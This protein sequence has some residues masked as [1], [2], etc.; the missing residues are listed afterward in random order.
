MFV[1]E[2]SAEHAAIHP[3]APPDRIFTGHP[4]K[5]TVFQGP[6]DL[7]LYLIERDEIDIFDIPIEPITNEYLHYL[8]RLESLNI[9]VCG[10]FL[11]MAAHLLEIK[12]RMLLPQQ[13]RPP[14]EEEEA[15]DPRAEL[16]ARLLEY[17]RYKRVAE[18]LRARA[19]IQ[20]FVFSRRD[21]VNGNGAETQPVLQLNEVSAFDLWAAFQNVL[22]RVKEP[23][24]GEV[25]RARFSVAQ[26]MAAVASRLK[27]S[28]ED[29][30]KF[31][32]LF[33]EAV[34]RIELVVTF[35][36]L[37]EL[38]RLRRVRVAQERIFGEIRVYPYRP[39]SQ[40]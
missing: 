24:E 36:A 17:R 8:A 7:L 21:L 15:G 40:A 1:P 31:E 2:Q 27:W 4:V 25:V 10:E 18:E 16:V 14:E 39:D 19:E 23:A 37:L 3:A 11:V 12:S 34:T 9:D 5:L 22:G 6:L 38:I 35:L 20:R 32:D 13:E 28:Q 29:G 26:K 30:L 33:D